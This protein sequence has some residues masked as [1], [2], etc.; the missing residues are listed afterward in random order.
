MSKNLSGL[1]N[2]IMF[3]A[4]ALIL[5]GVA[6]YNGYP[7]VYPDTGGYIGLHDNLLRSF[8]YNLFIFSSSGFQSLW[9]VVLVQS[10]IVA[11]L[12]YLV[13]RIV[14]KV[15]SRIAYMVL[16][17]LM[18]LLTN[19]PWFTGFIL[20]DIFTG[21]L[22]LSLYLLIIC[23]ANLGLWE[24]RYLFL[25]TVLSA[26]VHLSN[27][28]LALG[29]IGGA[30]LFRLMKKNNNHWP[31]PRLVSV[32][33]AI[34]LSFIL[35]IANNYRMQGAL[36]FSPDGYSYLLARFVADGESIKYLKESCPER[37]YKLCAYLDQL[38]DNSDNFLWPA[39]SPFR[40]VGW[41]NGYRQEGTE[42]V[43]KTLLNYPFLI[44]KNSLRNTVLQ[45]FMVNNRYGIIS[46]IDN[47]YPTDKIKEYYPGDFQAYANSRQNLNRLS[48]NVFNSI[49]LTVIF[50]SLLIST[51]MFF[52]FMKHQQY[53]P[54][55]LLVSIF[56]AYII[57]SFITGT[58]SAPHDRY[59]SRIIW[60]LPFFCIASLISYIDKVKMII[61]KTRMEN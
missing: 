60:L 35:I 44:I 34:F 55:L 48:L 3:L 39:E 52:T 18:C 32:C 57:S 50:L 21:A 25:L 30:L 14:F 26:T 22:I 20:P 45:F 7:L 31:V 1:K 24:R 28:P 56:F 15:T 47:P 59:G 6:F 46:Y 19:L 53:L 5:S 36:T 37:K 11:H 10:L 4:A 9:T 61:P 17:A 58:L 33:F 54:V 42:I 43:K 40:K 2:L 38:P 27:L 13:L 51:V 16:I 41:I 12:L 8:F 29:I 23:R 49:H